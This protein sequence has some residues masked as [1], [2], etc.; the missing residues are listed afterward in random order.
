[1]DY[2]YSAITIIIMLQRLAIGHA[3]PLP[4]AIYKGNR[5]FRVKT[6]LA[7]LQCRVCCQGKWRQGQAGW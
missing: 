7:I 6:L 1:M 3:L 4:S 5:G 2:D